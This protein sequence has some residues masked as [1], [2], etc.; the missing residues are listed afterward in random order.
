MYL[1]IKFTL[2]TIILYNFVEIKHEKFVND[3]RSYY[4]NLGQILNKKVSLNFTDKKNVT[5]Y[6]INYRACLKI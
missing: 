5:N 4:N 3:M 2:F 6:I 1:I